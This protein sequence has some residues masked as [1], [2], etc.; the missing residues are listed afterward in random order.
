VLTLREGKEGRR[1]KRQ[2]RVSEK[3]SEEL[4]SYHIVNKYVES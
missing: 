4:G 3:G 2:E 1:A